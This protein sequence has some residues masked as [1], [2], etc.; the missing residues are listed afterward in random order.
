MI[1]FKKLLLTSIFL[2]TLMSANAQYDRAFGV[3]AGLNVPVKSRWDSGF[4]AGIMFQNDIYQNLGFGFDICYN[5][6]SFSDS[7]L[8]S[9]ELPLLLMYKIKVSQGMYFYPSAG[10]FG[11]VFFDT[12]MTGSTDYDYGCC[13]GV[14][15]DIKHFIIDLR[16]DS[17]IKTISKSGSY[18]SNSKSSKS[19]FVKLSFGYM[20]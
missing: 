17:G 18:F 14:G 3:K 4:H 9:I 16:Y 15:V 13:F 1:I 7:D 12:S 2:V 10:A 6:S 8:H 11:T 20:F 19:Q 5:L